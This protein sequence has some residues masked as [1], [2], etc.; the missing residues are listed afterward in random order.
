MYRIFI[1]D[2]DL[3]VYDFYGGS[4]PDDYELVTTMWLEAGEHSITFEY[5][6]RNENSTGYYA[7]FKRLSLLSQE[8]K[9]LQ[10]EAK[11]DTERAV[12]LYFGRSGG[13]GHRDTLNLGVN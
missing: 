7:A 12:W 1:D 4:A 13:H 2:H 5:A 10:E 6:G 9:E 3:G 8:E 11:P